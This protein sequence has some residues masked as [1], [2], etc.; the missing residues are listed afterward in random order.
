[1]MTDIAFHITPLVTAVGNEDAVPT[2]SLSFDEINGIIGMTIFHLSF[3][4]QTGIALACHPYSSGEKLLPSHHELYH[5]TVILLF[6][7][8]FT[9]ADVYLRLPLIFSLYTFHDLSPQFPRAAA[10]ITFSFCSIL[11]SV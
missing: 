8:L 5:T 9:D 10:N 1:M 4:N 11:L 2:S 3:S 6:S 7:S